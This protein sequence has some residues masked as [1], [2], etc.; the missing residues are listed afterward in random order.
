M[1]VSRVKRCLV[2]RCC[3][4]LSRSTATILLALHFL[5]GCTALHR[6][7]YVTHSP[8]RRTRRAFRNAPSQDR[9]F[10]L[11]LLTRYGSNL[12]TSTRRSLGLRSKNDRS[13][14]CAVSQI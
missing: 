2:R 5:S 13:S 6:L 8:P 11:Q 10:L 4:V 7:Y 14:S 3:V 9:R 12:R 1:T